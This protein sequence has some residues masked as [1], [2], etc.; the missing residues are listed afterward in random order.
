MTG[1]ELQG[2]TA[3]NLT[4]N[5]GVSGDELVKL[6]SQFRKLLGT[7]QLDPDDREAAEA[8]VEAIEEEAA[9]AQPRATRV[10]PLMRRLQAALATGAFSGAE[11]GAKQETLHL[12]E[13]AR[14]AIIG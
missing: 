11:V 14:K 13:L 9:A 10:R 3:T 1:P 6:A 8:D 12:L 4:T 7:V 2:S 5:I